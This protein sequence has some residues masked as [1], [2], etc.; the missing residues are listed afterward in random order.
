MPAVQKVRAAQRVSAGAA[1]IRLRL[2][3]WPAPK[4][5]RKSTQASSVPAP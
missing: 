2:V 5:A 1:W 4:T 3:E